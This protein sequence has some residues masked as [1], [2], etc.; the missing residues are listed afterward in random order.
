M[1]GLDVTPVRETPGDT[2]HS[3]LA[4]LITEV[5]APVVLIFALL[6]VVSIH[7]TGDVG[8][9]LALGL[10]AAAF[11]GG[12][13]YVVLVLGVHTGRLGDRHLSRREERPLMMAMGLVSVTCGLLVMR[14]LKAPQ[15]VYALVAAMVAGVAVAL[16]ISLLWKIS[17]HA[18][19]VAGS[20]AVLTLVLGFR[21]LPLAGTVVAV[22]WARVQLRDH[23]VAQ[24]I[25]G[26]L[27]GG[28]VATV[29][30]ASLT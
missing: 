27:T 5:F 12:L 13:P 25:V 22:A 18:A 30:M 1:S 24:V 6:I 29:V 9:G 17:I 8:R 26:A 2:W 11:A 10:L 19:C 20:V 16:S 28:V 15:E 3:K 4:R 21:A 14:W 7:A 23:T